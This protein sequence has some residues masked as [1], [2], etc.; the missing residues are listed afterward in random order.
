VGNTD[1]KDEVTGNATYNMQFAL[2]GVDGTS[3]LLLDVQV[4][5]RIYFV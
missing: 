5:L 3:L 4:G 2:L 1:I